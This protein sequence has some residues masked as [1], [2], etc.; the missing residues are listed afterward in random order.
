MKKVILFLIIIITFSCSKEEE[1]AANKDL[2]VL[3]SK[4]VRIGD[5]IV[6]SG[7]NFDAVKNVEFGNRFQYISVNPIYKSNE[8]IKVIVP[9]LKDENFILRISPNPSSYNTLNFNL[10]GTFPLPKSNLFN[11]YDLGNINMVNENVAFIGVENRIY[12]TLDGGYTW[13]IVKVLNKNISGIFFLNENLGWISFSDDSSSTLHFTS[14]GGRTFNSIFTLNTYGKHISKIYF[15][16]EN[17]GFILTTKGE[18]YE[19]NDNSNFELTY[20]FPN[21][22]SSGYPEFNHLSVYN[23]NLI[24]SGEQAYQPGFIRKINNNYD[25]IPSTDVI[26]NSQL[27]SESQAYFVKRVPGYEDRLFFTNSFDS[28]WQETSNKKIHN[29]HFINKDKG[30]GLSSSSNNRTYII[31]ETYDGGKNWINKFNFEEFEASREIDFYNK[32]GLITGY[33]GKMWKHIF[34]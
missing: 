5:T 34:E 21:S 9:V 25:H 11:N 2:T 16:T 6:L 14:D 7:Q 28:N 17:H 26:R 32:V 23:N 31:F 3:S 1:K 30:I 13:A 12:K 8:L 4:K 20:H 33:R 10:I 18:I 22:S 19:T 15:S 29:F 24:A 27:V